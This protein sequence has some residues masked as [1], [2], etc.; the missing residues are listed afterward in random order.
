MTRPDAAARGPLRARFGRWV[1]SRGWVHVVLLT[2]LMA[3]LYPFL[4]MAFTATKTDEELS[5]TSMLPELPS[6]VAA[7]PYVRE[8]PPLERPEGVDGDAWRRLEPLLRAE[9]ESAAR[10]AVPS[11]QAG[12]Q[13]DTAAWARST[14]A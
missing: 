14:G 1:A 8:A 13:I 5:S 12:A 7:S 4:W 2:G 10:D 3:F 11:V 6:F 9:A